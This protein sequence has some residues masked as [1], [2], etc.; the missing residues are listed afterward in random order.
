MLII[1]RQ[2][3]LLKKIKLPLKYLITDELSGTFSICLATKEIAYFCSWA[4]LLSL[5]FTAHSRIQKNGIL[6][7]STSIDLYHLTMTMK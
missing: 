3:Y 6:G 2:H 7:S 1:L 4:T 5:M